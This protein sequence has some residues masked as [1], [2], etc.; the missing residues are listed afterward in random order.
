[1]SLECTSVAMRA[2]DGPLFK[3]HGISRVD[4]DI[5]AI[6]ESMARMGDSGYLDRSPLELYIGGVADKLSGKARSYTRHV[7]G[8]DTEEVVLRKLSVAIFEKRSW[9]KVRLRSTDDI[10]ATFFHELQH[11]IDAKN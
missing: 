2:A 4:I 10:Q 8:D 1:M 9:G 3:K 5:E 11:V 7:S 6:Y